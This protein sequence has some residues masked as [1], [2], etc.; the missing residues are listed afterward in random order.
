MVTKRRQQWGQERRAEQFKGSALAHPESA[1]QRYRASIESMIGTMLADFEKGLAGLYE[2]NPLAAQDESVTTQARRILSGL[3]RKWSRVFSECAGPLANRMIDQVDRFSKKNLSASLREMSGGLTIKTP[4]MPAV[5]YDKI[6][7]STA[8]NVALIKS[9]PA[10]Y[11]EKIQGIV[12]RSIQSGGQGTR[13][14]FEEIGHLGQVT[15]NRAKLIATD[16]TRKITAAM[17]DARMKSAGVKRF[18]WIHSGGSAEPRELHVEYDGQIFD[19]DDPPVIDRR[20]GQKGLPGVLIHCKC[21]MRPVLDFTQ[22]L[23]DES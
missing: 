18:E 8:E 22:Y 15:K 1:E 12:M 19:L 9:V 5:L 7:A 13:E 11:L 4:Q 10:Q 3:G 23:D 14:V 6:L 21:R 17:N 2:A 20:T 16:Q